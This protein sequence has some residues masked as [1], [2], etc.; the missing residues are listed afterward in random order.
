MMLC[1]VC[2]TY[3]FVIYDVCMN[4]LMHACMYELYVYMHVCI[5]QSFI[6]SLFYFQQTL[7]IPQ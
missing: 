5:N 3:V 1:D 7:Q 4:E 2:V 6:Q